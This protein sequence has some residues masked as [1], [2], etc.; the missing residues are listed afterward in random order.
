M[1]TEIINKLSEQIAIVNKLEIEA[2]EE[3]LSNL[4]QLFVDNPTLKQI[5]ILINNHEFADGDPTSFS[6][7]YEDVEVTDSDNNTFKRND[8]KCSDF[9]RNNSHPLVSAVFDLFDIYDVSNLY[10][11]IFGDEYDSYLEITNNN[12]SN[13]N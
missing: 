3:F 8:Y 7:Y 11:L 1:K 10:E 4:K 13:Y 12:V 6:L 9:D 5:K 2:K